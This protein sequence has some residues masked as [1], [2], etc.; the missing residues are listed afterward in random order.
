MKLLLPLTLT[1]ALL[2][3]YVADEK[4]YQ[5]ALSRIDS[6]DYNVALAKLRTEINSATSRADAAM[7]W[8]AYIKNKLGERN[9]ALKLLAD[10][11]Q[12]FGK[13]SWMDDARALQL[14]I[15]QASGKKISPEEQAD[16]DLKLMAIQGL[17]N[18]EPERSIPLLEQIL[19]S[20]KSPRLKKQA[21]FV[22]GQSS[23]SKAQEVIGRIAKGTGNPELQKMAI[24]SLGIGGKK[25][26]PILED[27]YKSSSDLAVKKEILHS[28]M[29]MGEKDRLG[30][31]A[32][33]EPDESLRSQAIHQLGIS[34]GKEYLVQ[35][36][37]TETSLKVKKQIMHGLFVGGAA[38]ELV[39]V[40][41]SEKDPE[42]K[43]EAFRSLSMMNSKE[44]TDFMMEILK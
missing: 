39:Q 43:K 3:G 10:M 1:G 2:L 16:E 18:A 41:R 25:N 30:S 5:E 17:M 40:A 20:Q 11:Q 36:Y 32:R 31:L 23:N 14:E 13:S 21:L 42:L 8:S 4:N 12:K 28:F 19:N 35:L 34:G 27:V 33:S 26:A 22:L 6:R 9:E 24:H 37:G 15:Q 29:I 44:A 38:K 7:Y